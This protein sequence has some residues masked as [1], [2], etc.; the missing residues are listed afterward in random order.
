MSIVAH[1]GS[2]DAISV[3]VWSY[4]RWQCSPCSHIVPIEFS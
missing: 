1:N 4:M 3:C 2:S